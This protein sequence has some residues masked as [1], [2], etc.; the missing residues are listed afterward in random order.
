E[1]L[2]KV[3]PIFLG[4][5]LDALRPVR[6]QLAAPLERIFVKSGSETEHELATSILVDYAAD[7]PDR[8]ASLVMAAD[9]KAYLA[10]FPIAHP[11]AESVLPLFQAEL[12]KRA[13]VNWD[14]PPLHPSWTKTH[15]PPACPVGAAGGPLADPLAFC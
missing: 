1:A 12:E 5:W 6:G 2:V 7:D 9:P 11:Q 10:L 3:N 14:D 13:K 15:P 8:L 4:H